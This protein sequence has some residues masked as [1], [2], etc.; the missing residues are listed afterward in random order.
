M[1]TRVGNAVITIKKEGSNAT[2]GRLRVRG[3]AVDWKPVGAQYWY[4]V[5]LEAFEQWIMD[6]ETKASRIAYPR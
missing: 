3:S 5:K 2:E 6:P 4:S 1:S